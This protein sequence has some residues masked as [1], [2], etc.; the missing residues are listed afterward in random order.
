MTVAKGLAVGNVLS[1]D[2]SSIA[3]SAGQLADIESLGA[4]SVRLELRLGSAHPTWDDQIIGLYA[5]VVASLSSAGL[6]V[7]GLVDNTAVYASGQTLWNANNAE[8]GGT[9]LGNPFLDAYLQALARLASA[10]PA[11]TTWEIWNEPNCWTTHSGTVYSG[12]SYM[13]PSLYASLLARAY[14]LLKALYPATTV[15]TGG[16]FGHDIGGV[17]SSAN[18]GASYLDSVLAVLS[19]RGIGKHGGPWPFDAA[20]QHLYLDQGGPL[21][22]GHITTY[23]GYLESVLAKY[24]TGVTRAMVTEI[25][26][27]SRI[28]AVDTQAANVTA[29]FA[30]LAQT[31]ACTDA[32]WFA[33]DDTT[34]P[35]W[36]V[37]ATALDIKPAGTAFA[38]V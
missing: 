28:V 16:L 9:G 29:A 30:E 23:L 37:Y 31:A 21:I 2:G 13:Y 19:Q 25:G 33:L 34:N 26:W 7:I 32:C 24:G 11:V 10:L 17:I 36:G 3:L 4:Q 1:A 5:Q 35:Q 14:P 20:G 27:N 18:S 8:N 22:G 38:A 15:L 6:R 12:S